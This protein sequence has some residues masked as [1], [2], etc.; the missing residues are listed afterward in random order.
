MVDPC[1]LSNMQQKMRPCQ[2]L[3]NECLK[4]QWRMCVGGIRAVDATGM[5]SAGGCL[6][7]IRCDVD[8]TN[9][10][11]VRNKGVWIVVGSQPLEAWVAFRGD[12]EHGAQWLAVVDCDGNKMLARAVSSWCSSRIDASQLWIVVGSQPKCSTLLE[13]GCDT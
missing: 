10:L 12:K 2:K 6:E 5:L 1:V 11:W 8:G 3:L 4:S 9:S 13:E 7:W